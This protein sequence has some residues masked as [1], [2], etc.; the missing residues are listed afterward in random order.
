MRARLLALMVMALPVAARATMIAPLGLDDLVHRAERIAYA[1]VESQAA[2]WTAD[3]SAIYTEVTLRVLQPMKGNAMAA[4]DT[5][6]LLREGGV[7]DGIGMKVSGA[8]TFVVGEEVV[9]FA[10]RRG[11]ALWTVGMAQG[12]MHV[13]EVDGRKLVMRQLSGLAFVNGVAP[14]EPLT[15]PLAELINNVIDIA[16]HAGSTR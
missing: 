16:A 14:P 5:I 1:R 2:R 12:K 13:A 6:T 11:Q 7:V 8:A 4:G 10:E 15:R 9:V 3:H